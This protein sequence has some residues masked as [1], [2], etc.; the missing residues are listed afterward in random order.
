MAGN[1]Y[2]TYEMAKEKAQERLIELEQDIFICKSTYLSGEEFILK[3]RDDLTCR[4]HIYMVEVPFRH[5][6]ADKKNAERE[7]SVF[8]S[9]K[10]RPVYVKKKVEVKNGYPF[11]KYYYLTYKEPCST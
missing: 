7:A 10:G 11:T 2:S 9:K 6:F 5:H 1:V 4:T 8:A 3:T